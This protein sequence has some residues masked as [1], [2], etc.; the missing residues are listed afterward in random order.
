MKIILVDDEKGIVEGLKYMINR[1]IPECEVVGVAYNGADGMKV[2]QRLKPDIVITDI[3]MPQID[4]LDMIQKLKEKGVRTKFILLSGYAEFEYARKALNLGVQSYINKPVEE[5]E[6]Q[7]SVYQAMA[8][9]DSEQAKRR[10]V[11]DLRQHF[12]SRV[13]ENA[14]REILDLGSDHAELMEEALE[15]AHIPTERTWF[16]G[17]ILEFSGNA[18]VLKEAV[19]QR[20]FACIDQAL[21]QFRDVYRFRYTGTQVAAVVAQGGPIGHDDLVR[22]VQRLKEDVYQHLDICMTAGVGTV[23]KRAAGISQSFEEARYALS[24]KVVNGTNTV[25]SY[26]DTVN[27]PGRSRSVPEAMIA[28]LEAA[29]DNMD[30]RECA[31]I[32]DDIFQAMQ[33]EPRMTPTDLQLQCL[34]ILLSSVRK[35]SFQQLQQNDFLGRHILSLEGMSKFQTLADLKDWM[36]QVIRRIIQFKQEH[37]I[38]HKKDI[39]AEVKEY[40]AA[41]YDKPITLADLSARFFIS[42]YYLSQFFKQK[43]GETYVSFLT[44]IR[45]G[46]AKELL[47]KTDLKVYEICERVGYSDTQYFARTFEKQTGLKPRDYRKSLPDV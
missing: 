14:L 26:S 35:M 24:Y 18:D 13:Q 45:I 21:G 11:D 30:E 23:Q 44:Q 39:I 4:G 34:N 6:L 15:R 32:I 7:D 36:I 22:S 41:H 19:L 5:E 8:A 1:Y 20:V 29:L 25:I 2:I 16:A 17:I 10:E 33:A 47:E 43:T 31:G 27:M 9:I 37:N 46:K 40:V 42:P 12:H 38:P 3:R 28:K